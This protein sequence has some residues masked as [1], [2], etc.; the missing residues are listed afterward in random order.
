MISWKILVGFSFTL[1]GTTS[2]TRCSSLSTRIPAYSVYF[3]QLE[4]S[5]TLDVKVYRLNYRWTKNGIP[6]PVQKC[7]ENYPE[8]RIYTCEGDPDLKFRNITGEDRGKY[9]LESTSSDSTR[10][11]VYSFEILVA[12]KYSLY[13]DCKDMT[14]LEGADVT[15]ICKASRDYPSAEISWVRGTRYLREKKINNVLVLEQVSRDQSGTYTC[16]AKTDGTLHN[17]SFNLDVVSGE[18]KAIHRKVEITYFNVSTVNNSKI[19][20]LCKSEGIPGPMY[21]IFRNGIAVKHEA[22]YTVDV[23]NGLEKYECLARNRASFDKRV[24]YLSS[25]LLV[26]RRSG[27]DKDELELLIVGVCSLLAG[28]FLMGILTCTCMKL[29][30]KESRRN[31]SSYVD[32]LPPDARELPREINEARSHRMSSNGQNEAGAGYELPT[33][34]NRRDNAYYNDTRYQELSA[35]REKDSERYQHLCS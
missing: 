20:L 33:F 31:A 1:I 23:E 5:F 3:V 4:R 21:T 6:I 15:C 7:N 32:V 13:V 26:K 24:L 35:F 14:V 9:I 34:G 25:V 2:F 17:A 22:K 19:T 30:K 29:G 8:G 18:P 16:F 27:K 12:E 28:V 10:A 11:K